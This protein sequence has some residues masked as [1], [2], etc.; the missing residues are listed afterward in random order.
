MPMTKEKKLSAGLILT[1]C[2]KFLVCHVTGR[3]FYDIPK[4]LVDENEKPIKACIREV[5]EETG[6]SI[7]EENLVDLGVFEYTREKDLHLFLAVENDLPNIADMKC[8]SFFPDKFGRQLPE[9]NGYKYISFDEKHL[10]LAKSMISVIDRVQALNLAD[11]N[12]S[13][14]F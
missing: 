9:V 10:F 7:F 1:D 4:G 3:N 5:A 14:K 12:H 11:C 8:T 13:S 2:N 6:L